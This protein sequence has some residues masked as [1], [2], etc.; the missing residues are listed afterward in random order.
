M[1]TLTNEE[2][3]LHHKQ[4]VCHICEKRFCHNDG[5]KKYHKVK[6]HCHLLEN[7]EELLVLL[8]I[9]DIKHQKKVR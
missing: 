7:I 1:I 9:F 4:E 6:D 3:K 2:K 8:V 5:N